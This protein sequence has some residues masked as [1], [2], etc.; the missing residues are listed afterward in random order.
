MPRPCDDNKI[1]LL[2]P[3]SGNCD[4]WTGQREQGD[5]PHLSKCRR[6]WSGHNMP[7]DKDAIHKLYVTE[8][9]KI[10]AVANVIKVFKARVVR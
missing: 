4:Y 1:A 8:C 2:L 7:K 9:K 5:C 3:C 10:E 6:W